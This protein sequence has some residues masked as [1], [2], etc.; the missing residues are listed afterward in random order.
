MSRLPRLKFYS[1]NACRFKVKDNYFNYNFELNELH[2][3]NKVP[4]TAEN[5]DFE[6]DTRFIAYTIEN[7]LFMA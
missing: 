4:D 2:W 6:K 7:N 5:I 3:I 1:D